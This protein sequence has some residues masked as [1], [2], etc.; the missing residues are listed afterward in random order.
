[1]KE[2]ENTLFLPEEIISR[3]MSTFVVWDIFRKSLSNSSVKSILT[4]SVQW[5]HHNEET[6]I[7]S[8]PFFL[9]KRGENRH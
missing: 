1:M 7:S 4:F 5:D 8:Q 9:A 3:E 6:F 2:K